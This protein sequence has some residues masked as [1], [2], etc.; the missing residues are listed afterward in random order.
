MVTMKFFCFHADRADSDALR[1][2][3]AEAHWSYMDRFAERMIARG[4]TL[5]EDGTLA[6]GSVHILDLVG[7]AQARAFAFDEPN[8]QAGVYRHVLLR[9]W[10]SRLDR[11]MWQ[12][13]G[14]SD[15]GRRFFVL[16]LGAPRPSDDAPDKDLTT[17]PDEVIAHGS[18]V[19]DDG[20]TWLGTVVLLRAADPDAAR[21]VLTTSAYAQIE[22]SP[23]QFGGRRE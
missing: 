14:G 23:W 9:R 11:T 22:V 17:D 10:V 21:A 6:T 4:P 7:V 5:T 18:L 13:P 15:G 3:L 16:G 19:S 8:Y 12:F 2:D 1:G 20:A